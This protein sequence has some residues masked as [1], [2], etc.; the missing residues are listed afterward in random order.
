MKALALFALL[1]GGSPAVEPTCCRTKEELKANDGKR[2]VLEG[3]Y[4]ATRIEMRKRPD[5]P[6]LHA[7]LETDGGTL[8]IGVYYRA[9]GLRPAEELARLDG[10]R[11]QVVGVVNMRTPSQTSPDG[12]PMASML[13]PCVSPVE[14]VT[15]L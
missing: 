7:L 4:R 10:K 3:V 1:L 14:R 6:K 15:A 9:D 8:V 11:V 13:E 2:V 12:I 5:K